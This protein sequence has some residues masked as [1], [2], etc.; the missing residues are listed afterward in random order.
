MAA[1]RRAAQALFAGARML[2]G[3]EF[4]RRWQHQRAVS[5]RNDE[6]FA[7][8]RSLFAKRQCR[9]GLDAF[10]TE[11][12]RENGVGAMQLVAGSFTKQRRT[13]HCF[14]TWSRFTREAAKA[15]SG[16]RSAVGKWNHQS[17]AF[18]FNRLELLAEN[19]R[20]MRRVLQAFRH[21]GL[22]RA[23]GT[24][25]AI[26]SEAV[27]ALHKMKSAVKRMKR[28]ELTFAF[29]RISAEQERRLR[30]ALLLREADE[31]KAPVRRL[32]RVID[33][34]SGRGALRRGGLRVA[35]VFANG[36]MSRAFRSWESLATSRARAQQTALRFLNSALYASVATWRDAAQAISAAT[37][38]LQSA[39]S[40]WSKRLVGAAWRSWSEEA[41]TCKAAKSAAMRVVARMMNR[42]LSAAYASW[43]DAFAERAAMATALASIKNVSLKWALLQW[44][45]TASTVC[46]QLDAM[47]SAVRRLQNRGRSR[48]FEKWSQYTLEALEKADRI[49]NLQH[50][51]GARLLSGKLAGALYLWRNFAT[52]T[53]RA[54]ELLDL[55]GDCLIPG[56]AAFSH[57]AEV[58]AASISM[59]RALL[60]AAAKWAG[61]LRGRWIAWLEFR[62]IRRAQGR[63]TKAVIGVWQRRDLDKMARAF[64]RLHIFKVR[65]VA[66]NRAV[67]RWANASMASGWRTW[68][69]DHAYMKAGAM[70][71]KS[72]LN[73]RMGR[74]FE[75]FKE[76]VQ[77][78]LLRYQHGKF[79][80]A[81]ALVYQADLKSCLDHWGAFNRN[82]QLQAE[83]RAL[84][85]RCFWRS[86]M[87]SLHR[88]LLTETADELRRE[89]SDH[90][91]RRNALAAPLLRMRVLLAPDGDLHLRRVAQACAA[92]YRARKGLARWQRYCY[93]VLCISISS[94]WERIRRARAHLH[95]W[96]QHVVHQAARRAA[97]RA[98][99]Q[100]KVNGRL[101][102]RVIKAWR[103]GARLR[104]LTF[105]EHYRNILSNW[106]S[107]AAHWRLVELREA[108]RH[109]AQAM[110]HHAAAMERAR[111]DAQRVQLE[112]VRANVETEMS[113]FHRPVPP[114]LLP[115][116][117]AYRTLPPYAT[118]S[119][120]A[121]LDAATVADS[122]AA[123]AAVATAA[124]HTAGGLAATG[125]LSAAALLAN[126][127]ASVTPRP[128]ACATP[129]VSHAPS[130]AL[131]A[132][133]SS[134]TNAALAEAAALARLRTDLTATYPVPPAPV[135]RR[136]P[137][138][139]HS[140]LPPPPPPQKDATSTAAAVLPMDGRLGSTTFGRALAD[141]GFG[142][143]G[144]GYPGQAPYSAPP[145]PAAYMLGHA[146]ALS[147][148]AATRA[149]SAA[150]L[151]IASSHGQTGASARGGRETGLDRLH[152][153]AGGSVTDALASFGYE[154]IEEV[155][156]APPD[157]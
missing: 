65:S 104:V 147:H 156:N 3:A 122:T 103:Q 34:W 150:A 43:L 111:V 83:R 123:A 28:S 142:G 41:Q 148:S 7:I 54:T 133:G 141:Y 100:A 20:M 68:L 66:I 125:G 14:K 75:R 126:A 5:A 23:L 144:G 101:L 102:S 17:L 112:L 1:Y 130:P 27:E 60:G 57:W 33:A 39:V 31:F 99:L 2:P 19:Q 140:A 44:H 143:G 138:A 69:I 29:L 106:G 48:G 127:S 105:P 107:G 63:R 92:A 24:W 6:A 53:L 81:A 118:P 95:A 93:Q 80:A 151:H 88:R 157:R 10:K 46:R 38:H 9:V 15:T 85:A 153:I 71:K 74:G 132:G 52:S 113:K 124:G 94:N 96:A 120:R 78:S 35:K 37:A 146:G 40:L 136:L 76:S 4:L 149:A 47:N 155:G 84:A 59:R 58:A 56:R 86:R 135:P 61:G 21:S 98:M 55:A 131:F 109:A 73:S 139:V 110:A 25:R 145:L 72:A 70:L 87:R 64:A 51:A 137:A 117:M 97:H 82:C 152:A 32:R 12:A 18:A 36:Q 134:T 8:A 45:E 90:H 79:A 16:L 89:A 62:E 30:N 11:F 116:H 115:Q 67:R 91:R 77:T 42:A 121:A 114:H 119:A 22:T 129:D 26:A 108:E 128:S 49:G 154:H 50:E 13:G